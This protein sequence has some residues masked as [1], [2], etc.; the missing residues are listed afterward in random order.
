VDT[1]NADDD[2]PPSLKTGAGVGLRWRSPVGMLRV[3]VAHPFVDS[4]DA[5]RLHISIGPEL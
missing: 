3:D 5:Y 4:D 1:G 2:F